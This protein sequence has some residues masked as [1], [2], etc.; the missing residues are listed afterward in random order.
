MNDGNTGAS[1]TAL[2][3]TFAGE[4][5]GNGGNPA[6]PN[7]ITVAALGSGTSTLGTTGFSGSAA[8][9]FA[10]D[11]TLDEGVTFQGGNSV[12]TM[13]NG[14]INSVASVTVQ[15]NPASGTSGWTELGPFNLF[16]G[17][18]SI[19][20]TWPVAQTGSPVS[21]SAS[22]NRTGIVAD[23]TTFSSSGGLDGTGNALSANLLGTASDW[24]SGSQDV[25]A[26][27]SFTLG[28]AGSNDVVSAAGQTI[29]LP[30]G[31][32]SRLLLL[33]VG[34]NGS[35]T[36]QGF[37]VNDIYGGAEGSYQ[38]VSDW[39]QPQAYT[40]E[41][42]A[43]TMAYRDTSAGQKQTAP[44]YVYGYS[45]NVDPNTT[46]R[47][48][49]LPD[50]PNLEVLA[51][52]LVPA[53]LPQ[54]HL[55]SGAVWHL[56]GQVTASA[57]TGS[58]TVD[59]QG[60][61]LTIGDSSNLC[62]TFG[63]TIADGNDETDPAIDSVVKAG[64]GTLL[65]SGANTYSGGATISGGTL[66]LGSSSALGTGAVTVNGGTLNINSFSETAPG[67]TLESGSVIGTTGVLESTSAFQVQSG[68]IGA[69]LGGGVGLDK[70]TS[71]TV[72]LSARTRT[73]APR[74]SKPAR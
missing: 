39:G 15:V 28:P 56:F 62:S 33:A 59:L 34:V 60:Y 54:V 48:I 10:G 31:N 41:S 47:S 12:G 72:T 23:Q 25:W 18:V 55:A 16:T 21:L 29:A 65:L 2:L 22:Y 46:I 64:T 19:V 42:I 36:N 53:I 8:T 70:T 49:T 5:L 69:I 57:L 24:A 66:Q 26:G 11:V 61:T 40:G 63:G 27:Q 52:D 20:G 45:F 17:N 74:R 37:G 4:L 38:S 73:P 44:S 13:W 14:L 35:Q 50:D 7:N 51:M 58:G 6:I 68:S 32:F 71:N 1:S 67:L 30:A 43:A 3:A 9:V